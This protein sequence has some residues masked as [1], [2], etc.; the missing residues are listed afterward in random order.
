MDEIIVFGK[1]KF[2]KER[3][4]VI[5]SQY[6]IV[7]FVDN[8][9]LEMCDE[10]DIPIFH[11]V[12]LMNMPELSIILMGYSFPEMFNQLKTLGVDLHRIMYGIMIPPYAPTEKVLFQG[13]GYISTINNQLAF[14]SEKGDV[15]FFSDYSELQ[16]ISKKLLRE[17]YYERDSMVGNIAS[18]PIYPA[19]R[20]FGME[21]GKPIDRVYIERFLNAQRKYIRG[22]VLEI[23]D[24]FYTLKFGAEAV[25]NSYVLHVEG[26][27]DAHKGNLENG[28]GIPEEKFDVAIITQTLMFIY[29]IKSAAQNIHKLLKRHGTALITV[30]GIS[31]I[32]RYD[33]ERWGS[34]YSF[35][36]DAVRKL[37]API[38]GKNNLKIY[39]YGNVKTAVAMLYGLCYE[40]LQE[41]DFEINDKDYPVII[42]LILQ[43][44]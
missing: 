29:D 36:E 37:F 42:A 21:R 22:N 5:R 27:V 32:S 17:R 43:K 38:F 24:N 11:P 9:A 26:G 20:K 44:E 1:G 30:S 7:A 10:G 33:A 6:K 25:M 31:Q 3:E 23:G 15:M 41:D 39:S 35:H 4:H 16:K 14:V 8:N 12:E 40:D 18:M 13:G 34:Y 2:Y 28:E 19:S